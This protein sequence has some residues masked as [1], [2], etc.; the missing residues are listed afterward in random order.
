MF[1][2]L[3]LQSK[4]NQPLPQIRLQSNCMYCVGPVWFTTGSRIRLIRYESGVDGT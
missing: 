3:G 4:K 2:K 1:W